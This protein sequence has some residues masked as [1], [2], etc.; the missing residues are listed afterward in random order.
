M[1]PK[2]IGRAMGEHRL[3]AFFIE[4]NITLALLLM[5]AAAAWAVLFWAPIG[6]D[7]PMGSPTKGL[8]TTLFLATWVVM[9]V[10]M[11]FPATTPMFLAFHREQSDKYQPESAFTFTWIFITAY[12]LVWASAGLAAYVGESVASTVRHSLGPATTA[13]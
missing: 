11:M 7:M 13:Q 6:M 9:M 10:A 8:H 3:D 4:R 5:L 12:L 1:F 2:G